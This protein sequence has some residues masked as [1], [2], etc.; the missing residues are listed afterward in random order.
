MWSEANWN[1]MGLLRA[2]STSSCPADTAA[3][4]KKVLMALGQNLTHTYLLHGVGGHMGG[5]WGSFWSWPL[6]EQPAPAWPP[7]PC[8]G[9]TFISSLPHILTGSC[10]CT[11]FSHPCLAQ[12]KKKRWGIVGTLGFS[13]IPRISFLEFEMAFPFERFVIWE[14][15][16]F[17]NIF[18]R[19][20][21]K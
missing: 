21:S 13:G 5:G 8:H 19:S 10:H 3:G 16:Q 9:Q 7:E 20:K 1:K 17:G 18:K 4:R 2:K 11:Q 15:K 6:W 14:E 12:C